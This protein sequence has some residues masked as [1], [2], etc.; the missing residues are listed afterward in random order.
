MPNSQFQLGGDSME[1]GWSTK[2][3]FYWRGID[4]RPYLIAGLYALEPTYLGGALP[5]VLPDYAPL[6]FDRGGIL[7]GSVRR[8]R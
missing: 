7:A 8:R 4:Y 2:F 3:S 6:D 1:A 5:V